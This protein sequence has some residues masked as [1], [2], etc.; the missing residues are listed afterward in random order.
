MGSHYCVGGVPFV[1]ARE[2]IAS[3]QQAMDF[4]HAWAFRVLG[5]IGRKMKA[6]MKPRKAPF[7]IYMQ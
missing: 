3:E 5:M 2:W 7:Y 4:N 6:K 1:L